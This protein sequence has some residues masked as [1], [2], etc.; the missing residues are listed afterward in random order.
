MKTEEAIALFE[1]RNAYRG[2]SEA[3]KRSYSWAVGKLG[4]PT[5]NLPENPEFMMGLLTEENL[6]L[7]TRY[8]LWNILKIFYHHLASMYDVPNAMAGLGPPRRARLRFPR[9]LSEEECDHLLA[10]A[11]GP[12]D[13]A[14]LAFLMDTGVRIG[15]VFSMAWE[16]VLEDSVIVDG[17][18]GERV[19]PVSPHVL[20]LVKAQGTPEVVWMGRRGPMTYGGMKSAVRSAIEK[21]GLRPPKAG[22]HVLRHTFA[23]RFIAN[24]GDVVI[25][26]K[27]LGHSSLNS[28]MVYVHM[29]EKAVKAGHAKYSPM[30][31][32]GRQL[33]L[34][35]RKFPSVADE[36]SG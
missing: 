33:G 28:T 21:S 18:T 11:T 19:V 7:A 20:R 5:L 36:G 26:Q 15:E 16:R 27:I 34:L 35:F 4:D 32:K 30:A 9:V 1:K 10:V 29:H 17:K 14:L 24:G 3:T 23:S 2:L 12:R 6:S 8:E 22:P 31:K 13:L 25:L